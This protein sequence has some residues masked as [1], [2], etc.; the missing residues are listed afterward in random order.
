MSDSIIIAK[1]VLLLGKDTLTVCV[2][3]LGLRSNF[4]RRADNGARQ[5]PPL[6]EAVSLALPDAPRPLQHARS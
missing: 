1:E 4:F 3:A 2:L 6:R 5:L